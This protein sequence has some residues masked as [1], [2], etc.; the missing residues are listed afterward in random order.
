MESLTNLCRKHSVL[1]AVVFG[2]L[3]LCILLL[4]EFLLSR[5]PVLHGT[6]PAATIVDL[7]LRFGLGAVFLLFL[8]KLCLDR[9]FG[10]GAKGLGKSLVLAWPLFLFLVGVLVFSLISASATGQGI[11]A[12]WVLLQL[13]FMCSVGFIEE[14][15]F[16]A[17]VVNILCQGFGESRR[18]LV[19]VAVIGALVF[20][21][22]H[23]LNLFGHADFAFTMTQVLSNFGMGLFLCTLYLRTGNIIGPMIYH[24]FNDI[25]P[26]IAARYLAGNAAGAGTESGFSPT[27]LFSF[28]IYLGLSIFYLRKVGTSSDNLK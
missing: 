5:I 1:F 19:K 11:D 22:A 15:I 17:G 13:V 2:L 6:T 8:S 28:V 3:S 27:F 16:R 7:I 4:L 25:V 24:A 9:P 26:T 21:L 12:G 20:S 23:C 14:I 10:F 18:D